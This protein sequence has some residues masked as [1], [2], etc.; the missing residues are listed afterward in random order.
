MSRKRTYSRFSQI[1]VRYIVENYSPEPARTIGGGLTVRTPALCTLHPKRCPGSSRSADSKVLLGLGQWTLGNRL[2]WL[3]HYQVS[4]SSGNSI[5]LF[6]PVRPLSPTNYTPLPIH[7][8]HPPCIY[9]TASLILA[10][11]SSTAGSKLN[12]SPN[13][14]SLPLDYD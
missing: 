10:V 2:N 3:K 5:H 4:S 7:S 13:F 8:D 14:S 12:Y 9:P 11:M 6:P 1:I